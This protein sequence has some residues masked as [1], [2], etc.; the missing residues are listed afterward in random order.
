VICASAGCSSGPPPKPRRGTL[1]PGTAQLSVDGADVGTTE[2]VRCSEIAWSTTIAT[3][4]DHAG[5]T[6]MVSN[7]EK[8]VVESVQIRN[9]N[10]FTGNYSRGL[11]GDASVSMIAATY[12]ITGNALG[13]EP[14]STTPIARPF[15]IKV[16]C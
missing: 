3:G 9:L 13:Y 7:A 12:R 11:N 14:N 5:V 8:L 15:D 2:A 10:N 16:A 6:V 4:D 1:P